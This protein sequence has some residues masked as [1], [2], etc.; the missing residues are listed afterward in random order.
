MLPRFALAAVWL[1]L[2]IGSPASADV[3]VVVGPT[4][5]PS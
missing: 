4:W 3:R 1:L 5:R 2:S